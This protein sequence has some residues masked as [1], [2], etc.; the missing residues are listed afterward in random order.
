MTP[1]RPAPLQRKAWAAL[2]LLAALAFGA[3]HRVLGYFFTGTDTLTLIETARIGS[4]G[5]FGRLWTSP[6]MAGSAF[7]DHARF[8]RPV[9]S[10]SYAADYAVWGLNPFGYHLT[11]LLLHAAAVLMAFFLFRRLLEG[12]AFAAWLGAAL[13][14]LHPILVETLPTSARRQDILCALLLLG[15]F[16]AHLRGQDPGRGRVRWTALAL[17]LFALA[18]WSKELAVIFPALIWIH[19]V[20]ADREKA[21]GGLGAPFTGPSSFFRLLPSSFLLY[22]LTAAILLAAR[23]AVL[24]GVGGYLLPAPEPAGG[25]LP[26]LTGITATYFLDLLDPPRLSGLLTAAAPLRAAPFAVIVLLLGWAALLGTAANLRL[27]R[28][29]ALA[30]GLPLTLLL[31]LPFLLPLLPPPAAGA[32]TARLFAVPA[33]LPAEAVPRAAAEGALHLTAALL[34]LGLLAFALRAGLRMLTRTPARGRALLLGLAWLLLPLFILLP[35]HRMFL[36]R[37]VHRYMYLPLVPYCMMVGMAVGKAGQTAVGSRQLAVGSGQWAVGRG[38][39]AGGRRKEEGTAWAEEEGGRRKEEENQATALPDDAPASALPS[40]ARTQRGFRTPAQGVAPAPPSAFR[41][42]PPGSA[43]APLL[44]LALLAGAHAAFSPL[45]W[46]YGE[47]RDSGR[48][49][50]MF[51]QSLTRLLPELPRE[52]DLHIGG[53]PYTIESYWEAFPRARAVNYLSKWAVASWITL[54]TPVH[55]MTVELPRRS[56]A[57]AVPEGIECRVVSRRGRSIDIQVV[58]TGPRGR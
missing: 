31:A 25:T 14:A 19:G 37:D 17:G 16:L 8:H 11:D 3:H 15:A 50:R 52:A 7:A 13:F 12:R 35:S 18:F 30:P 4:W 10:L 32:W 39:L 48:I 42:P 55:N 23:W 49:N 9:T 20:L 27:S 22:A 51:L 56:R 24:G 36:L 57:P 21:E 41:L 47:W 29:W 1:S 43:L 28:L 6:L 34:F 53:L 38:Q 40:F 54:H 46:S 45:F 5:D 2:V 26:A 58:P 33:G 44:L